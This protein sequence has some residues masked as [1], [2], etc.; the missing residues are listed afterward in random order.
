VTFIGSD[1]VEEGRRAA[2]WLAKASNGKAVIAELVGDL[3][4]W[5]TKI[6]IGMLVLAFI[7][8]QNFIANASARLK[9]GHK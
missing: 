9:S 5:W 1:F 4:T 6:V 3:N 7:L 8:L 2:R